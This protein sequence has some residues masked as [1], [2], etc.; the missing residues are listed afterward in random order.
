MDIA[1]TANHSSDWEEA[2]D[3][4]DRAFQTNKPIIALGKPGT[5]KTTVVKECIRRSQDAGAKVLRT[6]ARVLLGLPTAQLASRMRTALQS[7]AGV[8]IET[9]HAA[10]KLE[11]PIQESLPIMTMY[12][13]IVID[14]ISLLDM[15][16]F[17]R[18]IKLWNVAQ[19]VPAL[20]LLGDKYQLPGVGKTRAWESKAWPKPH[21]KHIQLI[22]AW[23]CK[24]KKFQ[25]ILDELRVS[26]PRKKTLRQMCAGHKA[27]GK[28]KPKPSDLAKLLA[29]HPDTQ[30]VTCT[31]KGAADVN[32]AAIEAIYKRKAPLAWVP[33][34]VEGNPENFGRDGQFRT[35]RAPLP[36][37]VPIYKKMKMFLTKNVRKDDDYVNGM[38]CTVEQYYASN[39]SIRVMT[40][41][42]HRLMITP[43]SD[44]EKQNANY[45]TIR[46][47]YASTIHKVQGDEF[48]HITI[49]LDMKG[50]RAAG[51]TALSRVATSSCYLLG[52]EVTRDHFTPAM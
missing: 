37:F 25:R 5:G 29:A 38:Q 11:Q 23:R 42:G 14:E 31:R 18:L 32:K 28:G 35:D 16:Q 34:D 47:G 49:W 36:C 19:K 50:M 33:G 13:L 39:N 40:K 48:K 45:F 44:K 12:D 41:T 17:E 9:C 8:E 27:W 6:E 24:E 21:C 52:G 15:P 20:V 46:P 30:I 26:K 10:F 7:F 43:W 51:Y 3:A 2:D 4:R 22:H 1:M